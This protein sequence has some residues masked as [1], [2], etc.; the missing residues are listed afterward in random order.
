MGRNQTH[1]DTLSDQCADTVLTVA[2]FAHLSRVPYYMENPWK[3]N[4]MLK[5]YFPGWTIYRWKKYTDPMRNS[6]LH[7]RRGN[8]DVI[9]VRGTY[10]AAEALQD[11]NLWMPAGFLQ[12]ARIIGPSLFSLRSILELINFGV[13]PYRQSQWKGLYNYVK[14]AKTNATQ[15]KRMLYLTGHS[16]G[17]GLAAAVGGSLRIRAVTFSAPGLGATSIMLDPP[18]G[19]PKASDLRHYVAN[20]MPAGDIVPMVDTQVGDILGIDCTLS[21][22][23]CHGL[24]NTVCEI[25]AACGDGAGRGIARNYR[26]SCAVCAMENQSQATRKCDRALGNPRRR[27]R[28]SRRRNHRHRENAL[29]EEAI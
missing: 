18:T 16:L 11:L 6:L 14:E 13:T 10:S 7:L 15:A 25:M 5:H 12:L 27:R 1:N 21:A 9:T 22:S 3:V 29:E 26:R 28:V 23:E 24:Q 19:G 8:T 17:G 20:V 2:D 4:A